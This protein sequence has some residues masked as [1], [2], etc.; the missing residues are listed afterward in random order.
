[1]YPRVDPVRRLERG[2]H[3]LSYSSTCHSFL[4][5]TD[6]I[7]KRVHAYI[8]ALMYGFPHMIRGWLA[9]GYHSAGR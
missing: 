4:L 1:M 6:C 5:T 8:Y 2:L 9:A 7:L 3:F